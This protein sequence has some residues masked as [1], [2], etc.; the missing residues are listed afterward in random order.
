MTNVL[1][2]SIKDMLVRKEVLGLEAI[3]PLMPKLLAESADDEMESVN[4]YTHV[5]MKNVTYT[6]GRLYMLDHPDNPYHGDESVLEMCLQLTDAWCDHYK[7]ARDA[8][9]PMNTT[10]WP[11]YIMT[12]L[13]GILPADKIGDERNAF[14]RETIR[15]W[16][17]QLI[18]KPFFFTSPNHEA[19]K[20]MVLYC[21]G[22]VLGREDYKEAAVFQQRQ[23]VHFQ[24]PEGFWAEGRHHGPSLKYNFM[25]LEPMAR[26]AKQSGDGTILAA[27]ERLADFMA[28][29]TFP[30]GSTMGCLDGR[31]SYALGPWLA[32][33]PGQDLTPAIRE[34]TRRSVETQFRYGSFTEARYLSTSNWYATYGM[35]M[36]TDGSRFFDEIDEPRT[37]HPLDAEGGVVERHSAR[38]DGGA[39]RRGGFVAALSGHLSDVPKEGGGRFRLQRQNRIDLWHERTGLIVGGGH[40]TFMQN[41]PYASVV[42]DTGYAGESD[43]GELVGGQWDQQLSYFSARA[44]RS[45]FEDGRARIEVHFAHGSVVFDISFPSDDVAEIRYDFTTLGVKRLNIQLVP[46]FWRDCVFGVD[47]SAIDPYRAAV[48]PVA[49]SIEVTNTVLGGKYTIERVSGEGESRLRTPL[50]PLRTYGELY[51]EELFDTVWKQSLLS[52][53]LENPPREGS[54][55]LRVTVG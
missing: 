19:W 11:P 22:E 23:E 7:S 37:A 26:I 1:P 20:C 32:V 8:G 45:S 21:A 43:F 29:F 42:M 44:A 5:S 35:V 13:I 31:Q 46:V 52:I 38:M 27:A 3:R 40:G 10:E 18:P 28:E 25:Q 55:L 2:A 9:R 51:D 17:E 6:A 4:N 54:G 16:C 30:D 24:T 14:W 47:G 53:Q 48:H 50:E 49:K 33:A 39:I 36:L 34:M 12:Q 41:P 15:L